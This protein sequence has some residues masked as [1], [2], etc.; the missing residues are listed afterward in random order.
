MDGHTSNCRGLRAMFCPVPLASTLRVGLVKR[1]FPDRMTY[2]LGVANGTISY[3]R[4]GGLIIGTCGVLTTSFGV[5]HVRA[6][7]I[8][9]VPSRTKVNNNSTS[10]TCVVHLLSR[11]FHLG[12]NVPRV[13]QCTTGLNTSYT[14]FVDT[15]PRGKSATYCTRNVNSMLV[16][17]DNPKSGVGKCCVII[18]GHSSVTM[19]AGSTCTTVAPGGPTG[20]YHSVIHRPVRA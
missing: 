1:R 9:Q 3:S 18:I 5:P 15:S 8:G 7:L 14:C 2:S 20:Y 11:H 19:D 13:R 16:P 4:R 10:T 17:M 12:V 6:R